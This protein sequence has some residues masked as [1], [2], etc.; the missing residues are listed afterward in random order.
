MNE[1]DREKIYLQVFATTTKSLEDINEGVEHLTP[2]KTDLYRTQLS[3]LYGLLTDELARL[4]QEK[5]IS[6]LEVKRYFNNIERTKPLSDKATDAEYDVTPNGQRRIELKYRLKAMEKM[7]SALAG[8][9]HRINQEI[10][11]NI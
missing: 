5:A 8:R 4:E 7:I 2:Q 1:H 10:K 11:M 9:M 3:A 6:W